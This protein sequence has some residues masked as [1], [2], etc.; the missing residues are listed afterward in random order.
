MAK[1]SSDSFNIERLVERARWAPSGDN[2]QP[3]RFRIT[4][5]KTVAVFADDTSDEVIY[6]YEGE[7][8]MLA[9]GALLETF[10]LAALAVGHEVHETPLESSGSRVARELQFAPA[11]KGHDPLANVIE[12]RVTNRRAFSARRLAA[13]DITA[14][15]KTLPA[16][17]GLALRDS[18]VARWRI[19]RML[20]R[21]AGIRLTTPE[22]FAVHRD[23]VDWGVK[24]SVDRIPAPAV[25][26]DPVMLGT[27]RWAMRS[28]RRVDVLNR[29]F[30]GTVL[31]RLE[32]DLLPG[33]LCGAHFVLT[34]PRPPET[35]QDSLD[36][37]AA[38]QRL[39]L[40]AA[41]L[42]IQFQPTYSPLV[43]RKYVRAGTPFTRADRPWKAAQRLASELDGE[44]SAEILD[45][46]VF[47]GRLGYG[48]SPSARSVRLPLDQL[49]RS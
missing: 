33:L 15:E 39:W 25:G 1:S 38:M 10:R 16:G 32:L 40:Q 6:D 46:T 3:W 4:A 36:A 7:A 19:A 27:M 12:S 2:A 35:D 23:V 17:Y 37:G 8:S 49:L 28:W 29:Y 34:A 30:G 41:A 45:R 47:M 20:W 42:G 13:E 22:A 44:Y 31:P 11:N 9:T 21:N 24:E 48:R 14:M 43:F 5:P 18:W 26:L